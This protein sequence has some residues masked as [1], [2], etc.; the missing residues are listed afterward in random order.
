MHFDGTLILLYFIE[1][2]PHTASYYI[3]YNYSEAIIQCSLCYPRLELYTT[4]R[5]RNIRSRC[6]RDAYGQL[7]NENLHTPLNLRYKPYRFT[8]CELDSNNTDIIHCHGKNNNT[9]LHTKAIWI[10]LWIQM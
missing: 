3:S 9:G 7:R 5:D 6:S 10:L 2:L 8:M 4:D 1:M